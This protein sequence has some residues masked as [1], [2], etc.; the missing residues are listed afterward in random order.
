[1]A[2]ASSEESTRSTRDRRFNVT[3]DN[4]GIRREKSLQ[5]RKTRSAAK[6]R[7][8]RKI[9]E[10]TECFTNLEN[11]ADVCKG[12][13]E[14][15]EVA[16]NFQDAHSAYHATL[17]D[18]FEIQD[19]QEY[20]DCKNQRIVNFERTLEEWFSRAESEINPHDSVSNTGSRSRSRTSRSKSLHTSR[21]SSE[22]G[23]SAVSPRTIA[24]TKRASLTA[25]AAALHQQQNLQEE[26]LRLKQ[27]QEEARLR[28][29]QRKQQLHL[30]TE[31]AKMEAEEQVYAVAELGD[32]NF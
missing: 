11:V 9:K 7:I 24:A 16:T 3:L 2:E 12:A 32:Y 23:S 17:D 28:L 5:F 19:S 13:Q 21:R 29:D 18:D 10:L 8:T 4:D 31:I 22:A 15:E 25:E 1:M 20:F 6:A 30:Q 14:F 26:E 27:Q